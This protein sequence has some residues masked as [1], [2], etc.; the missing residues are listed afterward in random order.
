MRDLV[1]P[2]NGSTPEIKVSKLFKGESAQVLEENN[3]RKARKRTAKRGPN[4]A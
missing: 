4:A 2:N 1:V 3:Q